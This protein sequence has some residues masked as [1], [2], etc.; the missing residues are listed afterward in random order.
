MQLLWIRAQGSAM[1][2]AGTPPDSCTVLTK[3]VFRWGLRMVMATQQF[4][5]GHRGGSSESNN[6]V[7]IDT[8]ICSYVSGTRHERYKKNEVKQ[9]H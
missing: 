2:A 8:T 6:V 5:S 4:P 7:G 3:P 9:K 1:I